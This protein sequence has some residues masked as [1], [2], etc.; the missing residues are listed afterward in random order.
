MKIVIVH[1][2]HTTRSQERKQKMID[3]A[4][5]RGWELRRLNSN[6]TLAEAVR[7]QG[8]FENKGQIPGCVLYL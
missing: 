8:L 2:D 4:K 3:V 1:G 6:T 7:S 5:K